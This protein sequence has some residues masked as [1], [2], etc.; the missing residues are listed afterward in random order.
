VILTAAYQGTVCHCGKRQ[1]CRRRPATRRSESGSQMKGRQKDRRPAVSKAR[2]GSCIGVHARYNAA[3][4]RVITRSMYHTLLG[5]LL[6][7]CAYYR[8]NRY[9]TELCPT[10][11]PARKPKLR[12]ASPPLN[13]LHQFQLKLEHRVPRNALC[14]LQPQSHPYLIH[15][16]SSKAPLGLREALLGRCRQRRAPE[17]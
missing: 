12:P 8:H 15:F 1:R 17:P 11:R 7:Y 14:T 3:L 6:A 4:L 9:D 2:H 10:A 5:T 13:P 16:L